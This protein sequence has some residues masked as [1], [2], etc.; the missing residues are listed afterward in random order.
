MPKNTDLHAIR[1]NKVK[2]GF[3]AGRIT[4]EQSA[5]ILGVFDALSATVA[6]E[7]AN[8][9][10]F[11]VSTT[12]KMRESFSNGEA[13]RQMARALLFILDL[14]ALYDDKPLPTAT[15]DSDFEEIW[16]G[17]EAGLKAK[18]IKAAKDLCDADI[19][20]NAILQAKVPARAP[21][22]VGK[23]K[24]DPNL[25]KLLEA[26]EKTKALRRTEV[27]GGLTPIHAAKTAWSD[28]KTRLIADFTLQLGTS[29]SNF[30]SIQI[31]ASSAYAEYE[32]FF[33]AAGKETEAKIGLAK[34][35]FKALA[36]YTPF[37]VSIV[38]K[39]GAAA[40][41]TLAVDTSIAQTRALGGPQYFNSDI[42]TLAKASAKIGAIKNWATDLTTLGVRS[43]GLSSG[44]S[45]KDRLDAAKNTTIDVLTKIFTD[46]IQETYGDRPDDMAN[47]STAFFQTVADQLT[48]ARDE[49]V[50][51]MVVNKISQL[52]DLTRQSLQNLGK[53]ELVSSA[54]LQPFIE[55]QLMAEYMAA[56]ATN[57]ELDS[58][59]I[60]EALIARLE[61][62]PFNLVV[63]KTSSSKSADI[64]KLGKI[65]WESGHPRHVGALVLFFRWYAE[66]VNAFDI[67]VGRVSVKGVNDAMQA[68]IKN[69]G[70]TLEAH[71]V[72]RTMRAADTADWQAASLALRLGPR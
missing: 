12:S 39:I 41:G 28:A 62:A 50:A 23:L 32:E 49:L 53:L 8:R 7:V 2:A 56:L 48:S 60:P 36:D 10:E 3:T 6:T 58:V 35:F 29:L 72:K 40:C 64:Y 63:R 31:A 26:T 22:V 57:L 11:S 59:S 16:R 30:Q 43:T 52:S 47:K 14:T 70:Q 27:R 44:A 68:M 46:A 37:P 61:N 19:N 55:L 24:V 18:L 67:A 42:P 15:T 13:R 45:I 34:M 1:I 21:V 65:P 54:S 66:N 51:Q 9:T 4:S 33:R 69:I 71:K 25:L 20:Y 38:G 5:R 17:A